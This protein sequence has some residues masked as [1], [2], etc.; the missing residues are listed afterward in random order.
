MPELHEARKPCPNG[1]GIAPPCSEGNPGAVS[2]KALAKS[3][4]PAG[5]AS[6]PC[7]NFRPHSTPKISPTSAAPGKPLGLTPAREATRRRPPPHPAARSRN[8][9]TPRPDQV[10]II[11]LRFIMGKSPPS[12]PNISFTPFPPAS[13]R[14]QLSSEKAKSPNF[15]QWPGQCPNL[16]SASRAPKVRCTFDEGRPLRPA[17]RGST[18]WLFGV[19]PRSAQKHPIIPKEFVASL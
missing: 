18:P 10:G 16:D 6:G 4:Q 15:A 7:R 17:R 3:P 8:S 11:S 5:R 12:R 19:F 14:P 13:F 9:Q 2:A 1:G